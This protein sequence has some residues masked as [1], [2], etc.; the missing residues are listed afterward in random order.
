[1]DWL[2]NIMKE[3]STKPTDLTEL[4]ETLKQINMSLQRISLE[5][6]QLKFRINPIWK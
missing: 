4:N 1:M 6:N 2:D 3:N 5:L